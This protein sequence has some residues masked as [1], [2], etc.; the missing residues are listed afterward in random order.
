MNFLIGV[1]VHVFLFVCVYMNIFGLSIFYFLFYFKA[2]LMR[3][4]NEFYSSLFMSFSKRF[5]VL[6]VLI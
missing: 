2:K 4:L 1:C 3:Q 5:H 6:Y